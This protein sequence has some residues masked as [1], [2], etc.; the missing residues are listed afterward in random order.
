MIITSKGKPS[1]FS[2]SDKKLKQPPQILA[3]VDTKTAVK[4]AEDRRAEEQQ[5]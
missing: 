4:M 5:K 3:P 1:N 2:I